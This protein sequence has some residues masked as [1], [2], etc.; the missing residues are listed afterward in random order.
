MD[1][2]PWHIRWS[3]RSLRPIHTVIDKWREHA[4]E[5]WPQ[6]TADIQRCSVDPYVTRRGRSPIW[7]IRCRIGYR[8]GA[9]QV[10]SSIRS[11]STAS[12][13]G[14]DTGRMRQWFASHPGGSP[15]IVRYDPTDPNIAIL[16][17]TDMPDAGPRTPTNL[18]LLLISSVAC[19]GLLTI[20]RLLRSSYP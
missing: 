20:A 12:G 1:R 7:H 5:R 16:A 11:R 15:I 4:Q 13:R 9:N 3:M 17:A 6:V 8:V 18:K 2:T 14:G 10:E 19:L